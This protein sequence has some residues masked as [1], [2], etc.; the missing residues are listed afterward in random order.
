MKK[1]LDI[2]FGKMTDFSFENRVYNAIIFVTVFQ[3]I[4]AAI[5]N[6]SKGMPIFLSVTIL[7][8][9]IVCSGF[10]YFSRIKKIFN[11][12]S[13]LILSCILLSI[14]WFLNE[15]SNGATTFLF[16]TNSAGI[17]CISKKNRHLLYLIII[18]ITAL[19]LLYL[20]NNFAEKLM[21]G[22]HTEEERHSDV[23]FFFVLNIILI[24]FIVSF[25]KDNYDKKNQTI[26]QQKEILNAQNEKIISSIKSAEFIQGALLPNE[27]FI[28]T[29]LPDY[30]IFFKPKDIVS[31]DFYWINNDNDILKIVAADCTGHGVSGALMSV[32]GTVFLNEITSKTADYKAS[33]ILDNLRENVKKVLNQ[34]GRETIVSYGM[35]IS[36]CLIEKQKQ[37][38]QFAG[39]NNSLLYFRNNELIEYKADRMPIGLYPKEKPFTN[40]IIN[41]QGNDIFYLFSDGYYSQFGG[42]KN[43]KYKIKRM[44]EFLQTIYHKPMNEQKQLLEFEFNNW[45]GSN[46]QTD[47][48]LVVGVRI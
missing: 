19:T 32:L 28:K 2:L 8:I 18:L 3:C 45:K 47:D 34:P 37:N 30:F 27:N 4:S 23:I 16:L 35:D 5:Y 17:I 21:H 24:Y 33:E 25:L 26:I 6:F 14:V 38:M 11:S 9:A 13:Y 41:I 12:F 44:K 1:I 48:V 40:H 15:G 22:H 31:G 29:F 39:A 20:E 42:E 36:I 10:Y 7:I 46:E 43:N